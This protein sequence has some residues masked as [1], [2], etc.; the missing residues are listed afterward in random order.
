MTAA[1]SPM[2]DTAFP[3]RTER[4]HSRTPNLHRESGA[5]LMDTQSF[6][7]QMETVVTALIGAGYDPYQQITGY[8]Q[9]GEAYYITRQNGARKIIESLDKGEVQAYLQKHF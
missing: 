5:K 3:L 1:S 4:L 6:E 9:T 8:L 2:T 7:E